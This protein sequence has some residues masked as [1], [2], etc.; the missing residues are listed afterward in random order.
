MTCWGRRCSIVSRDRSGQSRAPGVSPVVLGRCCG[1]AVG[2]IGNRLRGLRDKGR[3]SYRVAGILYRIVAADSTSGWA[4]RSG[5]PIQNL[6]GL[7]CCGRCQQGSAQSAN[8]KCRRAAG[9]HP[10]RGEAPLPSACRTV[11]L[12]TPAAAIGAAREKHGQ[13]KGENGMAVALSSPHAPPKSPG[14]AGTLTAHPTPKSNVETIYETVVGRWKISGA[15]K[16][17]DM[18]AGPGICWVT[19]K[20]EPG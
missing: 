20:S 9:E 16:I 8:W 4:A 6:G 12:R 5:V 15:S 2:S 18:P 3:A 1:L 17:Q 13:P 14:R 7:R 10:P 11:L 19:W